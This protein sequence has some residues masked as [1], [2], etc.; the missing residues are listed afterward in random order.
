MKEEELLNKLGVYETL[1]KRLKVI[2]LTLAFLLT[3]AIGYSYTLRIDIDRLQEKLTYQYDL[4]I[5]SYIRNIH[6][7]M[8][9]HK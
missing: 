5:N 4:I 6:N 2:I 1:I 8:A 7:W 9:A 3:G